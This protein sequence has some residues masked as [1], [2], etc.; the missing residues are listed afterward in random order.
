MLTIFVCLQS[1][2]TNSCCCLRLFKKKNIF[3]C[4]SDICVAVLWPTKTLFGL[5]C[6]PLSMCVMTKTFYHCKGTDINTR[7]TILCSQL[8]QES[9]QSKEQAAKHLVLL[10]AVFLPPNNACFTLFQDIKTFFYQNK[11]KIPNQMTYTIGKV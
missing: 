1:I 2:L 3:D 4:C 10:I 7:N 11:W 6:W 5:M 9:L 8:N